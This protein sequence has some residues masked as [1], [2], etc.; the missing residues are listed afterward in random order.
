MDR[1]LRSTVFALFAGLCLAGGALAQTATTERLAGA[2]L[3]FLKQA[4]RNG[5]AEVEAG[6]LAQSKATNAEVKTFAQHMIDEHTQFAD[7]LTKLA[8]SKGV[9][10]PTGPSIPQRAKLKMLAAVSGSRFD[11]KFADQ[12]GVKAHEETVELFRNATE[13]AKDPDVKAFAQKTLTG[14]ERHLAMAKTMQDTA[15]PGRSLGSG[16]RERRD[17]GEKLDMGEKK[18]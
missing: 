5:H 15:A 7:E 10:L 4:A 17:P 14:L 11:R 13:K 16:T 3:R 6:K 12:F 8:A 9:E 2:D 1:S 18:P